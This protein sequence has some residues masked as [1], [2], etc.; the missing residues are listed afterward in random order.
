[1]NFI[2]LADF[3]YDEE[4]LMMAIVPLL[5]LLILLIFSIVLIVYNIRNKIKIKEKKKY[6]NLIK[7]F[8]FIMENSFKKANNYSILLNCLNDYSEANMFIVNYKNKYKKAP[9]LNDFL[10][11]YQKYA[12]KHIEIISYEFNKLR[13][14]KEFEHNGRET[15]VFIYNHLFHYSLMQNGQYNYL[16]SQVK[17]AI[18]YNRV[19]SLFIDSKNY[20]Q[21]NENLY[22]KINNNTVNSE[23]LY[24]SVINKY[25]NITSFNNLNV[26]RDFDINFINDMIQTLY[27]LA[28]EK[29]FNAERYKK[30]KNIWMSFNYILNYYEDDI[31]IIP[32]IDCIFSKIIA[33]SKMGKG[34]LKQITPEIML[35][36]EYCLSSTCE[37][38]SDDLITLASGLMWLGEYDL[39]LEI[40]RKAAS[41]GMQLKS[42]VQERLIF[43]EN[44]GSVGPQ[45]YTDISKEAF[46]YDYSS[47][48][49]SDNDFTNFFKN[50]IFKNTALPY[51]LAVSEFRSSFKSKYDNEITYDMILDKLNIMAKNE[52]LED[53]E[54][55]HIKVK[56]LTEDFNEYDDAIMITL[57]E[58][59]GIKHAAILLFY[60]KIGININIQ[61]LTLFIPL[62]DTDG[63]KNMKLA[64]SLKQATTPK[65]TQILDSIRDSV[66]RQIDELCG[67]N[68]Y[69]NNSIY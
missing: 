59:I 8:T 43:L 37:L 11:I 25:N 27:V 12:N 15:V 26:L 13:N 54:C 1:M 51:A 23:R 2:T 50:L 60:N 19:H 53:I 39:E 46:N 5:M 62:E 3:Y 64:I 24:N 47:L 55:N 58:K 4:R 45:L 66:A 9:Y 7:N 16:V 33:Y 31:Y 61:I 29:T 40:L 28:L 48:K 56:S 10:N 69:A 57:A 20:G 14:F 41:S 17:N 67:S 18:N 44:G 38:N 35:W 52:Y 30:I 42:S 32:P 22:S 6:E 34:V 21:I 63:Q 36:V 68:P 65:V 49:W